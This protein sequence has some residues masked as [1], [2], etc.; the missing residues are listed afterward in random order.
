MDFLQFVFATAASVKGLAKIKVNCT[1]K[2]A[3]LSFGCFLKVK[4]SG[5]MPWGR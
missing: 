2:W 5:V 4:K 1:C 3:F